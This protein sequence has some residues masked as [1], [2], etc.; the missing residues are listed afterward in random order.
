[1]SWHFSRAL[2][3]ACDPTFMN[4]S[5]E[6]RECGKH[7]MHDNFFQ[8]ECQWCI[9]EER[10]QLSRE[11]KRLKYIVSAQ[12][13]PFIKTAFFWLLW[14]LRVPLQARSI[15]PG[16]TPQWIDLLPPRL[17]VSTEWHFGYWQYRLKPFW[18]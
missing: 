7:S 12:G 13:R 10:L 3:E 14:H 2:V 1:M 16:D 18:K 6:R 15:D 5:C 8:G 4:P 17:S 11:V 9:C